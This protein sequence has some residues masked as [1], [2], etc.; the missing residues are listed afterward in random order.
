VKDIVVPVMFP[1]LSVYYAHYSILHD[2]KYLSDARFTEMV[3][4]LVFLKQK[5]FTHIVIT[6]TEP[7]KPL[8]EPDI[9]PQQFPLRR[10][11]L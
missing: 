5:G 4:F 2:L 10:A 8:D 3:N 1:H 7:K 6:Q 11:L 9:A